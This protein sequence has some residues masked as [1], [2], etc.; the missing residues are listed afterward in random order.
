MSPR[1][2]SLMSWNCFGAATGLVSFL[3]W[4]GAADSHR[5]QHP[6][7]RSA[8][9]ALDVV[10]LQEVFLGDAEDF[11]AELSHP[12]KARDSNAGTWAPPTVGGSGLAIASRH[13]LRSSSVRAFARPQVGSERFARKGAL[14]A[15]IDLGEGRHVDVV[16][17][18]MQS[19]YHDFAGTVRIQQLEQLRAL[20]DERGA[21]DR[22]FVLSG[23]LNVCGLSSR[24]ALR[25]YDAL[26]ALFADFDDLGAAD[27]RPTFDPRPAKN[28]LARRFEPRADAQRID[29][30][31]FRAPRGG[32]MRPR[33]L[34]L[35]LVEPLA[36]PRPT[37]PSDH[38]AVRV[39]FEL[40]PDAPPRVGG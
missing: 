18:H 22:P 12:H 21:T 10:C 25:E 28:H 37:H 5:F 27:D 7:V 40:D 20:V 9:D 2:L 19:G 30:V 6:D 11:F 36:G 24:R 17:T 32:W 33:A 15:E 3:R 8:V 34:E 14:H 26:R 38:F 31:L 4:R 35:D 23:D 13:K 1:T 29:Y 39:E 16:T